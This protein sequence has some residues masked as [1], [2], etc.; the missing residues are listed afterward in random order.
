MGSTP[1]YGDIVIPVHPERDEDY[2]KRVVGRPGDRFEVR[3][4]QIIL[5][6][7]PVPQKV[8]P[9]VDIPV[10]LNSTCNDYPEMKTTL[11]S[12]ER[13]CEMPILRETLPNGATYR[14]IDHLDQGLDN[15]PEIVIPEGHVFVMGDNRDHSA[16][17][18]ASLDALG[19]GGPIPLE[20]IG[21]RAEFITFS[22]DGTTNWNPISW[23]TSLREGR[24]FTTLRPPIVESAARASKD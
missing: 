6:G 8:E 12:G 20:N 10:D 17:S 1:E 19:L 22:L 13:V 21:G 18:R 9:P 2:I 5:N 7:V 23:F 3:N 16:D 14:I 4:G 15:Y 11:P 24:A